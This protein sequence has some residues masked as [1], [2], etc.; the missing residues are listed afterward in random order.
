MKTAVSCIGGLGH[1]A[2]Q[3][4]NKLGYD[5]TTFNLNTNKVIMIKGLRATYVVTII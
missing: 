4:L 1:I 5:V 2:I 3:F